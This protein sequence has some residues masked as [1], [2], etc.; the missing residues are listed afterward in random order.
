[1]VNG[2]GALLVT[3]A[4]TYV[5]IRAVQWRR[6]DKVALIRPLFLLSSWFGFFVP[7]VLIKKNGSAAF[8]AA[9]CWHGLQYLG[10]VWYFNR[11]RW[12]SGVDKRARLVSWV[13]QPKR[14]P[15]YF[16]SLLGIAGIVYGG[17]ILVSKVALTPEIWGS[18]VWMSLT[19]GH[20]WLDGVIW[21]LRKPEVR[22]H[23]VTPARAT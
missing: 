3:A 4:A 8:A 1:M 15:F 21:K 13:S 5:T 17:I 22:K 18:L 10:I 20:Y 11:N 23:L 2:M 7:F 9:A 19:L 12:N 14:V 16:L 6:G